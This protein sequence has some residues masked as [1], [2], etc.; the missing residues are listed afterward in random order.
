MTENKP[1]LEV[2]PG[3]KDDPIIEVELENQPEEEQTFS[4]EQIEQFYEENKDSIDMIGGLEMLETLLETPDEQ[5]VIIAPK[6]LEVLQSTLQDPQ[7]RTEFRAYLQ[8]KNYTSQ[9]ISDEARAFNEA[10]EQ[11][12]FLSEPKK[13]VLKQA[14]AISVNLLQE[15]NNSMERIIEIPCEVS[16]GVELPTY[17]NEGDAG[18]DIYSPKEY[19]IN[20]GET[21]II[22]TGIKVAIP[23]GYAI[24]IQP[25]SGQS[26]KTKLRIANTPGLIDSGYR[27]E[28]GVIIENIEPPF[29]DIEYHFDDNGKP[30]IDSILH[31]QADTIAEGQRFAQMRLVQVPTA[32]FVQV[33]SVSNL[34]EDRGGGFGHTGE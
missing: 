20:P 13:D 31:G 1:E 34:G 26:V 10:I 8:D 6:F 30:I 12:D 21:I 22:P 29:K 24:L 9:D 11:M 32:S 23:K 5:F 18:L 4:D 19:T 16:E 14:I 2:L 15:I 17:A 3:G 27:D 25:R 28:I 7:T 33:D